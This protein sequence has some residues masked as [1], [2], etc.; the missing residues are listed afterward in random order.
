VKNVTMKNHELFSSLIGRMVEKRVWVTLWQLTPE[1]TRIIREVR[2]RDVDFDNKE[3]RVVDKADQSK[4]FTGTALFGY[5]REEALIF[6]TELLADQQEL[7]CVKLPVLLKLLEEDEIRYIKGTPEPDYANAPWKVK[8]LETPQSEDEIFAQ[9]REAPRARP[10]D[11]KFIS[12]HVAEHPDQNQSY[13]LIDMSRGGMG[14]KVE[15]DDAFRVGQHIEITA[16]E[17]ETLEVILLGEVMSVRS[18][19]PETGFKVGVKFVDK[20]PAQSE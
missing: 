12:C 10:K 14:F 17:G 20:I 8:R 13:L 4:S 11:D 2:V 1:G 16:I 19:E 3:W 18:L 15:R 9:L 6:K 5:C 7:I